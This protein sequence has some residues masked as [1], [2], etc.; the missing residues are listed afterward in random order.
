MAAPHVPQPGDGAPR[1]ERLTTCARRQQI[2]D[3]AAELFAE[4][5]YAGTTTRRVAERAGVTEAVIFRHF[6]DKDSL[7]AAVLDSKAA[8]APIDEWLERTEAIRRSQGDA[9]ALAEIYRYVMARHHRDPDHLRLMVY[10]ALE[11]HALARRMQAA[12]SLRLYHLLERMIVDGQREGRFRSGP[13]PV[14]ARALLAFPVFCVFQT[15]LFRSPWPGV[16]GDEAI[17]L[18]AAIALD[19]ISVR[20][21]EPRLPARANAAG[22]TR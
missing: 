8:D 18:G 22:G 6:P 15:G 11:D 1:R 10:S 5:G 21:A 13:V 7:Y 16:D 12:Q 20:Q 2:I 14:L 17:R 4:R 3:V 19:G 9:A